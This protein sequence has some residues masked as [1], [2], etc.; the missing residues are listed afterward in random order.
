MSS[1]LK[2]KTAKYFFLSIAVLVILIFTVASN[3][4]GSDSNEV[5]DLKYKGAVLT[6][7]HSIGNGYGSQSSKDMHSHLKNIGYNYV[8]LNTFAYMRNRKDTSIYIGGDPSMAVP[9]LESE[10]QN[11]HEMGFQVILKP[12]IWIGG[13]DLDPDNWRSKI[14]FKD[15]EKREKWFDS[16]TKF[17]LKEAELAESTGAEMLV[18]G[19]ELVGVS[20]YTENWGKLIKKIREVYRGKLTYAA[21]GINAKNIEFWDALDYIGIDAYFA[22]NDKISPSLDEL[23]EG[24]KK[25]E[26]EIKNLSDKYG[27]QVIF[28]EIGYKSVEGAAIKPWEWKQDGKTSE[29]EQALAFKATSIAFRDKPYLAG[30]FVWKYFTDMNSYE[31]GNNEKGFTPYGK[32]AEKVI[33]E[34]FGTSDEKTA[35]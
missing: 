29:E 6:H 5:Y 33:S 13:H 3:F 25:F 32:E 12:H 20:K 27:K 23:V 14:D 22:L 26:P 21:E 7:I 19:T 15:I 2:P 35:Q 10:I 18:V 24:W 30:V 4:K 34:W 9:Y 1:L 11:L 8:Q 16:Y 28:T 31:R 17:I